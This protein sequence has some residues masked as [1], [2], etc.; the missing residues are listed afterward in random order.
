MSDSRRCQRLSALLQAA[1]GELLTT[2]LK[3]PRLSAAGPVTVTGVD[4]SGDLRIATVYVT[5]VG[6]EREAVE[7]TLEGFASAAPF[8]RAEV[9]KRIDLRHVPE[10][11]FRLDPAI[12]QGRR[13]DALLRELD[14]GD[15]A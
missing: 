10:L 9:G 1:L 7:R 14:E 4:V 2:R 12:A 5:T 6:D 13:M 3:D 8:L 15:G 11:R